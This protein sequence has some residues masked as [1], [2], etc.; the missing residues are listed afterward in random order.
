VECRDKASIDCRARCLIQRQRP[1]QM[2]APYKAN[3]RRKP[4]FSWLAT[5]AVLIGPQVSKSQMIMITLP[6]LI[7]KSEV[8]AFGH[9]S[10][11][12]PTDAQSATVSFEAVSVLKGQKRVRTRHISLCNPN[13]NSEWPD[14]AQMQGENVV[15][16]TKQHDCFALS[17]GY[18]SEIRTRKGRALTQV[19]KGEPDEQPTADFL[20]KIRLL[21]GYQFPD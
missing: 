9:R 15:F 2:Q 14:L 11:T 13:D 1:F 4:S 6:E 3:L 18:R 20:R 12:S 5:L 21:V 10:P 16:L 17:H 7:Q 19:I 8:I